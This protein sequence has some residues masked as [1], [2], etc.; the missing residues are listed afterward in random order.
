[1]TA[2]TPSIASPLRGLEALGQSVWFDN[3]RRALLTSGELER[4]MR[5]D[6]LSGLTSNPSI[7]EKAIV[8]S[9]DYDDALAQLRGTSAGDAKR[10]YEGL[11]IADLRAAA[12]V[13]RA[14]YDETAARDGTSAWRSPPTW[15]TTPPAPSRRRGGCGRPSTDRT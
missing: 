5:E 14:V 11:A 12:D 3:M 7:F 6:G 10:V 8:G 9:T 4:M 15:P 2:Y 1:M 13:V